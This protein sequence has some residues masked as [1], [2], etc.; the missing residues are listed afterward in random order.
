M[1]V[2]FSILAMSLFTVAILSFTKT[3]RA[4][5]DILQQLSVTEEEAH[6][7]IFSNFREGDLSFPVSHCLNFATSCLIRVI[8]LL[9]NNP[10]F[11]L[12]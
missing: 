4:Y 5:S 2:I 11:A 10:T 6:D 1:K 12:L 7:Y 3:K 9:P 8:P